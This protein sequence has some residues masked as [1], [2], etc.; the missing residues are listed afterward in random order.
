MARMTTARPTRP[1]PDG[2]LRTIPAPAAATTNPRAIGDRHEARRDR[3]AG[4]APRVIRRVDEVVERADRRLEE[5][6]REPEP[7][8]G[9]AVGA[10]DERDGSD[11]EPVEQGREGMGQA[12]ERAGPGE[13]A[14]R[15]QT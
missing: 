7:Q 10:G 15:R 1:G 14:R 2:T 3:L 8:R 5:D 6:H 4:L 13:D 11:D 12:D 9:P